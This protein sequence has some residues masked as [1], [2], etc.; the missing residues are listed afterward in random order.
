MSDF[1]Q[2]RNKRENKG[3]KHGEKKLWCIIYNDQ[4]NHNRI[5]HG[6]EWL[7]MNIST[8][9]P[10]IGNRVSLPLESHHLNICKYKSLGKWRFGRTPVQ[11]MKQRSERGNRKKEEK[12]KL[13]WRMFGRCS[14]SSLT[15][16]KSRLVFAWLVFARAFLWRWCFK[17]PVYYSLSNPTPAS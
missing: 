12:D 1:K 7:I 4:R 5:L 10:D 14:C 11:T 2:K 8:P 16:H 13:L 3:G 6:A 15:L 17:V 9:Q